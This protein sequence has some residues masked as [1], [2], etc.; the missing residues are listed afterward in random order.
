MFLYLGAQG[1]WGAPTAP[2]WC[3]GYG[4]IARTY[5]GAQPQQKHR[6]T[7]YGGAPRY[8]A[9]LGQRQMTTTI[10]IP[11]RD[12]LRSFGEIGYYDKKPSTNTRAIARTLYDTM[13]HHA[14]GNG[15]TNANELNRL[16]ARGD[17]GAYCCTATHGPLWAGRA[18]YPGLQSE[19]QRRARTVI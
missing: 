15:F 12:L 5:L 13:I 18:C 16:L 3:R 6:L 2:T 17:R 7:T 1:T 8:A 10:H 19:A 4:G 11:A 9:L 14:K